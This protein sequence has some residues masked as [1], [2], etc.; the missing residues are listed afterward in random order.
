MAPRLRTATQSQRPQTSRWRGPQAWDPHGPCP[1]Q[2]LGWTV[3]LVLLRT[4]GP[5]SPGRG[6]EL[7]F[8]VSATGHGVCGRGTALGFWG[9]RCPA[10]T[11]P[12]GCGQ[13]CHA[14]SSGHLDLP[15]QSECS[16]TLSWVLGP[17][18]GTGLAQAEEAPSWGLFLSALRASHLGDEPAA[19]GGLRCGRRA[20]LQMWID[21]FLLCSSG[22]CT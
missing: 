15:G 11:C 12:C 22:S 19:P 7:K 20:C 1:K 2:G 17:G 8:R 16:T 4:R 18:L 21:R 3:Q 6:S 10:A 5:G 13:G 14:P 9:A